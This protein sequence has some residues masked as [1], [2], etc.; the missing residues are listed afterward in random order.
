MTRSTEALRAELLAV[1][2]AATELM[3]NGLRAELDRTTRL[4]EGRFLQFAIDP[5][6]WDISSCASEELVLEADWL[7]ERLANDWFERA[8]EAEVNWD[9]MLSDEVCPWFANCWQMVG[10]PARFSPAY[11]F[12]HGFH[13]RQY[14]LQR[15]CWLSSATVFGA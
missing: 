13:N 10:G 5:W 15:Q 11:L 3:C 8:G 7:S 1:L 14:D 2:H 4:E 12:I 6:S 9:A